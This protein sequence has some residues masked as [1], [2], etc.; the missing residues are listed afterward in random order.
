[1]A[2]KKKGTIG[3]FSTSMGELSKKFRKAS[4]AYNTEKALAVHQELI[5]A[6]PVDTGLARSNWILNIGRQAA[7]RKIK[8]YAP[9]NKLGIDERANAISAFNQ[10]IAVVENSG[11]ITKSMDVFIVNN[12]EYIGFIKSDQAPKNFIQ[13]AIKR[14]LANNKPRTSFVKRIVSRKK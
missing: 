10:G 9:G 4:L 11:R 8:P 2:K 6:T 13:L 14:G 5:L 7:K 3:G 1:M 12:I